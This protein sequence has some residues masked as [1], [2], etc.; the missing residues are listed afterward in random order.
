MV[1]YRDTN[2]N[3]YDS[4][5]LGEVVGIEDPLRLGR[6]RVHV[7]GLIE[8][9]AWALPM[10]MMLGV[11]D[12]FFFVPA[13]GSNVAVFLHQGDVDFPVYLTGNFG[14]PDGLSDVPDQAN[15]G[16][17]NIGVIRW[18]G[19]ALSFDGTPGQEK[20][21][22]EDDLT[23]TAVLIDRNTKDMSINSEGNLRTTVAK[24]CSIDVSGSLDATVVKDMSET[25]VGNKAS[26]VSGD[27]SKIISGNDDSVVVGSSSVAAS[28]VSISST[29]PVNVT[30]AT[31][32][33]LSGQS[34]NIIGSG[35]S[36]ETSAGLKTQTFLGGILSNVVGDVTETISG[37]LKYVVSGTLSLLGADISIGNGP[38]QNLITRHFYENTFPAHTHLDPV[39]G[40]TGPAIFSVNPSDLTKDTKAS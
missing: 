10:G 33:N 6:V 13:V 24:D 34:V 9:S 19:F 8:P 1:D 32:I 25:I 5:F 20:M 4:V 40:A 16:D 22:I 29:G 15:N 12:G 2:D 39:S 18:R 3:R 37:F 23:G 26:N 17:P 31:A 11:K 21:K 36:S 30:S 28:A 14:K 38:Y 7:P 27:V 35:T